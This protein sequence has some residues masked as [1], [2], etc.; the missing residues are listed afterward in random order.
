MYK[1]KE[2]KQAMKDWN[3]LKSMS[4][5]IKGKY[6]ELILDI[7]KPHAIYILLEIPNN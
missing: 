5:A 4:K 3:K 2:T 1:F 7:L 6:K